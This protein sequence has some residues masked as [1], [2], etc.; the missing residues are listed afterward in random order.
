MNEKQ[1]LISESEIRTFKQNVILYDSCNQKHVVDDFLR[2]K[3]PALQLNR[4]EVED[5]L[6]NFVDDG[7]HIDNIYLKTI[8]EE[9]S[10]LTPQGFEKVASGLFDRT[11]RNYGSG[12]IGEENLVGLFEKYIGKHIDIYIKEREEK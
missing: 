3:Q 1:Y 6:E 5:L 2:S 10:K 8:A 7:G 12:F 9:I 4:E 11:D